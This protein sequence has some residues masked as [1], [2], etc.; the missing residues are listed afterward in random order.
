MISLK[1]IIKRSKNNYKYKEYDYYKSLDFVTIFSFFMVVSTDDYRYLLKIND[2]ENLPKNVDAKILEAAWN[3]IYNSFTDAEDSNSSIIHFTTSKGVHKM[4]LEY[5]MLWNIHNMMVMFP[6]AEETKQ[7]L[8]YAGIEL[9]AKE[10]HKKLKGLSNKIKLKRKDIEKQTDVNVKID[11]WEI[12][13]EIESVIGRNIDVRNTTMR[14][15]LAI[16]KSI[17]KNNKPK[18]EK[19]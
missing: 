18:K 10:I 15:Y 14:Q 4:E 13:A 8:K 6:N 1:D 11:V 7:V 17:K 5:L 2:Y 12:I 3:K 9:T 19:V 16:K